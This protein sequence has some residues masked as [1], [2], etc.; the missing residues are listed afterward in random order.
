MSE[1]RPA[2]PTKTFIY[3]IQCSQPVVEVIQLL[4]QVMQSYEDMTPHGIDTVAHWF[5]KNYSRTKIE[6]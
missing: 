3:D 2:P 5:F 1:K 4:S 6:E